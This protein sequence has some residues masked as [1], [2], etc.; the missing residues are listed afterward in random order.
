MYSACL[1]EN[2]AINQ[3]IPM[4]HTNDSSTLNLDLAVFEAALKEMASS[5]RSL[6]AS[7]TFA[8][9]Q[10]IAAAN[11]ARS[12]QQQQQ[13]QSLST[14][15]INPGV[16]L[17]AGVNAKATLP[18]SPL[19]TTSYPSLLQEVAQRSSPFMKLLTEAAK[20]QSCQ[21]CGK[22]KTSNDTLSIADPLFLTPQTTDTTSR[23]RRKQIDRRSSCLIEP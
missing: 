23:V 21:T 20:Q 3:P 10:L 8:S 2:A 16:S 14:R 9:N 18:G 6:T 13:Q 19:T 11:A 12:V 5:N 1:N 4:S 17:L 7:T 22:D 15:P